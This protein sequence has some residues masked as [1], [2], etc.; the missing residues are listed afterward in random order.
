MASVASPFGLKPT[1]LIGGGPNP[2]GT[3]REY[4]VKANNTA[5][6]F[7][8]DLVVLSA[9]GLPS[10]VTATPV[11]IDLQAT[12]TNATAGIMGVCSGVR[13]V[14]SQGVQ[15]FSQYLPA[16]ATTAGFTDIFVRVNDNP[17]QL[18]QVQGSEA[19]GTFNSGTDGSGL[20]GAV[21]K[22]AALGNF[23]AHRS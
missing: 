1:N 14:D 4:P 2:G 16:N 3:I 17:W 18:Y 15:Q 22:N 12:S 8:G 9:A 10:A 6:I 5:G 21:G 13:Y 20:A 23:S 19:L 7:N 11:S